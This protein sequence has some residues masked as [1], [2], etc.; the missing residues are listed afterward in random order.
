MVVVVG[1]GVGGKIN[2]HDRF[3]LVWKKKPQSHNNHETNVVSNRYLIDLLAL[4]VCN[5]HICFRLDIHTPRCIET[6]RIR[7][8]GGKRRQK[9]PTIGTER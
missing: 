8:F 7:T 9:T 5:I 6:N 1:L 3:R 2:K 4:G